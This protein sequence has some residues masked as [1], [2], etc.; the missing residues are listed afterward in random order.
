MTWVRRKSGVESRG[1]P[2]DDSFEAQWRS[3]KEAEVPKPPVDPS[4]SMI[5]PLLNAARVLFNPD[6]PKPVLN[7]EGEG[8]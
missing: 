1:K 5:P 4:T 8:Y 3:G 6:G 2:L 7:A